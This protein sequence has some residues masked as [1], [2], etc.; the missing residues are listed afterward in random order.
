MIDCGHGH[1]TAPSH[2]PETVACRDPNPPQSLAPEGLFE[3]EEALLVFDDELTVCGWNAEAEQLT[4]VPAEQA[5][6]RKCY[7]VLDGRDEQGR[8]VCGPGC[9]HGRQLRAGGGV[10]SQILSIITA[11]GRRTVTLSF[12][13]VE[14]RRGKRYLH[15]MKPVPETDA[16]QSL[17]A[18]QRQVLL[19]LA[20]G[21]GVREIAARL[22]ISVSTVR[23]HVRGVLVGLGCHSQLEAVSLCRRRGLA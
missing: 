8:Q 16:L 4:G 15:P 5:I 23:N 10:T 9:A 19:L 11:T 3:S 12:L 22:D 1:A 21:E 14:D 6:G 18:R 2:T 20:D 17:T 13:A 7:E